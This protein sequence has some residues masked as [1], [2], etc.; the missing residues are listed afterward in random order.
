MSRSDLQKGQ[1]KRIEI[2]KSKNKKN[3]KFKCYIL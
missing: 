2:E 3:E 1:K